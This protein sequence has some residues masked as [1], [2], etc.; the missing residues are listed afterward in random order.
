MSKILKVCEQLVKQIDEYGHQHDNTK[1]ILVPRID[2]VLT[3]LDLCKEEDEI[4]KYYGNKWDSRYNDEKYH[5][6]KLMYGLLHKVKEIAYF[7][8]QPLE[9]RKTIIFSE[10]C[11]S[12]VQYIKRESLAILSV[13]MRSSDV[14]ALL[15]IDL[16]NLWKILHRITAEYS[17]DEVIRQELTVIIGSAHYYV[18]G[19]RE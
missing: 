9:N 18:S 3:E 2:M 11:I 1:E 4:I 17:K 6:D 14:K 8:K 7:H 12:S 5:Y 10:D 19:G 16:L 15:P 13:Y